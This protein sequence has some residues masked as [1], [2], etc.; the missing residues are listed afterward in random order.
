[1]TCFLAVFDKKTK[2]MKYVNASHEAPIVLNQIEQIKNL[3]ASD[4]DAL[5]AAS[6]PSS[7]CISSAGAVVASTNAAC[8]VDAAGTANT[9][10]PVFHLV[11][12]R[13]GNTFTVRDTWAKLG[14]FTQN[15]VEMKYRAYE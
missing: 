2:I 12:T 5:F 8:A 14:E 11:V 15:N 3:A 1:M 13:S 6:V 7:F 9:V 4:P 10:E